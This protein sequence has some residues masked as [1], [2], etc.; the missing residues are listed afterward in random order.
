[1]SLDDV[2]LHVPLDKLSVLLWWV[3]CEEID[4]QSPYPTYNYSAHVDL[5]PEVQLWC[6]EMLTG[7]P[8]FTQSDFPLPDYEKYLK[9]YI[10]APDLE[11]HF[12]SEAEAML[13]KLRWF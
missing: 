7:F 1:M 5:V 12:L 3:E 9:P 11:L 10:D 2:I 4:P 6:D 8:T 13:F